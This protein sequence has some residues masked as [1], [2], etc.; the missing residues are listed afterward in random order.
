MLG[1][2]YNRAS[3]R[4]ATLTMLAALTVFAVI[5]ELKINIKQK[6][7]WELGLKGS[8]CLHSVYEVDLYARANSES[9]QLHHNIQ[10]D[11]QILLTTGVITYT[12]MDPANLVHG[13]SWY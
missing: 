4:P 11:N 8:T 3:S 13:Y 1:M 5:G 6:F 2:F 7:Q 12:Q 10:V 9:D